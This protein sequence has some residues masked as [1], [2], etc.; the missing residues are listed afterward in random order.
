MVKFK[1]AEDDGFRKVYGE[2]STMLKRALQKNEENWKESAGSKHLGWLPIYSQSISYINTPIGTIVDQ[3]FQV[4]YSIPMRLPFPKNKNFT[5]RD[6]ELAEIHKALHGPDSLLYGQRILVLHGFGGIGKTQLAI[7]YAYIHQKDYTSVWWIN[8]ST[9][10]TFIQGVLGIAKQLLSYLMNN[11]TDGVGLDSARIAAAL[12]L[13]PDAVDQNG[14]LKVSQDNTGIV[15]NAI[16]SWFAAEDNQWL[17]IID[18]YDDSRNVQIFDFLRRSSSGS[19]LITSQSQDT[20]N[21]GKALEV[22]EVTECEA[23][24]MLRKSADMDMACFETG[25]NLPYPKCPQTPLIL[26]CSLLVQ[27]RVTPYSLSGN[28]ARSHLP[29]TKPAPIS[30]W[31]RSHS[32]GTWNDL[33]VPLR[34]LQ[35]K[36]HHG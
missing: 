5:G 30:V 21:I 7:Q 33:R 4:S 11:T 10:Q 36:G 29:S 6:R 20:C 9:T 3:P 12:G 8:A 24:E 25:I 31:C 18:N 32:A 34:R 19:I 35:P 27:S 2:L 17:L 13:P 16:M 1:G 23:L 28:L 15:V 22:Q 14:E 26:T